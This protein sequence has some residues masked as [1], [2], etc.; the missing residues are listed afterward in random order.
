MA[1]HEIKI[2]KGDTS[3]GKL[4]LRPSYTQVMPGDNVTWVIDPVSGVDSIHSIK[5]KSGSPNIFSHGPHSRTNDWYAVVKRLILRKTEYKYSIFWKADEG[6][7]EY[8]P[9]ISVN[10]RFSFLTVFTVVALALFSLFAVFFLGE[11]KK[12]KQAREDFQQ[13]GD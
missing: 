2:L 10:P 3:T 6:T 13:Y 4:T 1:D 7:Y 8:D 9:L 11:K 5:K 12:Q